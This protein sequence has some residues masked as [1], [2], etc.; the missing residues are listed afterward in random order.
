MAEKRTVLCRG[1]LKILWVT[2]TEL[3]L[4]KDKNKREL[5]TTFKDGLIAMA[6]SLSTEKRR[7]SADTWGLIIE[8]LPTGVNV[9]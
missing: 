9:G 6:N 2:E 7:V 1:S 8:E 3:D 5:E 4:T